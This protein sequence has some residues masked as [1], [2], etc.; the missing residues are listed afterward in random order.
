MDLFWPGPLTLVMPAKPD[1]LAKSVTAGLSTVGIRMP[2]H[3]VALALLQQLQN[4]LP[5]RA[6]IVVE[7]QV[8]QKPFMY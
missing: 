5:H 8:L 7:S 3:P 6:L 2:D 1:V 4:R